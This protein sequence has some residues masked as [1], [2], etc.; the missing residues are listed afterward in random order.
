MLSIVARAERTIE[1]LGLTKQA[2]LWQPD[3]RLERF[4][5]VAHQILDQLD[6]CPTQNRPVEAMLDSRFIPEA[7]TP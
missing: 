1:M 5:P 2:P 6:I 7:N 3:G 4:L